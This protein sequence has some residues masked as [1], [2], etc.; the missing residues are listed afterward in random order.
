M[1][2]SPLPC[3]GATRPKL[4]PVLVAHMLKSSDNLYAERLLLTMGHGHAAAQ[5]GREEKLLALDGPHRIVD[6]SG[7]SRYDLLTPRQMVHRCCCAS[8]RGPA[9]A[10]LPVAGVDGTLNTVPSERTGGTSASQDGH[11][12][13]LFQPV[14][15]DDPPGRPGGLFCLDVQRLPGRF[16][17]S[18]RPGG[19]V[20][21]MRLR[22]PRQT[23]NRTALCV[24]LTDAVALRVR[25]SA[26]PKAQRT[27][28]ASPFNA[29]TQ[30]RFASGI[31]HRPRAREGTFVEW[32]QAAVQKTAACLPRNRPTTAPSIITRR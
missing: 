16:Q 8:T 14:R 22:F 28:I 6:S 5:V 9:R 1:P 15:L 12:I 32:I 4:S 25:Y 17:A 21:A 2:H 26:S 13:G 29:R 24:R 7:L 20:A 30:P 10:R 18:K 27:V 11:I 31:P 19:P 23:V 3:S